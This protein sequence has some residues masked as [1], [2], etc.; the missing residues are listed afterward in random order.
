MGG[1]WP[2]IFFGNPRKKRAATGRPY[3]RIYS[4]CV[5]LQTSAHTGVAFQGFQPVTIHRFFREPS[6]NALVRE[7]PRL[8]CVKGAVMAVSRKAMTEGLS[9]R[10]SSDPL[11]LVLAGDARDSS[12][13]SARGASGGQWPP[14]LALSWI[15]RKLYAT[16][17]GSSS[18]LLLSGEG[19]GTRCQRRHAAYFL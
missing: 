8:P 1:H 11:S 12:P 2:P 19:F 5:S 6:K 10:D 4:L 13:W 15:L 14:L 3:R 18:H 17:S 9:E 7:H 16:S